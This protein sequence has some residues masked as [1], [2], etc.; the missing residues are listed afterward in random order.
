MGMKSDWLWRLLS[1][2]LSSP[3]SKGNVKVFYPNVV[4]P[5]LSRLV[6][7]ILLFIARL[8]GRRLL[9]DSKRTGEDSEN[10]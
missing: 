1:V 5:V 9:Q 6:N 7:P 4:A 8:T 3:F 2:D 10:R